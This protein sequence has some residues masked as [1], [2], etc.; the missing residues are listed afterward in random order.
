M[1]F[2]DVKVAA[3]SEVF[4]DEKRQEAFCSNH[5]YVGGIE[6][7]DEFF[8]RAWV[9]MRRRGVNRASM[10][11]VFLGDGAK[12]IW[13]RVPDVAMGNSVI[14]LDFFHA[15]E[16]VSEMCKEL[17][18]EGSQESA[19]QFERWRLMLFGGGA[20]TFLA[21][22]KQI[23]EEGGRGTKKADFLQGEIDYFRDNRERMRYDEYPA[24]RLP[25]GS[26]TIE[27]A[28]KN[29]VAGRMKRGGMTWSPIG[30]DGMVQIRCSL[31]AIDSRLTSR[32]FS[33]PRRSGSTMMPVKRESSIPPVLHCSLSN[34]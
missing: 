23:L 16:H 34:P 32:Q 21:E 7:A 2:R 19:Q 31:L 13:D 3:I 27:S 5:S 4:W 25:I 1:G 9:E 20:E 22:V 8:P 30:A 28:C 33:P 29:V 11:C 17:Y 6:H 18:G 15:C 24:Q 12:W 14:I 10:K 26:G